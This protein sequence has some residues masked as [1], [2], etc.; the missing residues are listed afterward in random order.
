MRA[1]WTIP[2]T[3]S[4]FR[5]RCWPLRAASR[6]CRHESDRRAGKK[7]ISIRTHR[8]GVPPAFC[9]AGK[10]GCR[11]Q[12][13]EYARVP[14]G[15]FWPSCQQVGTLPKAFTAQQLHDLGLDDREVRSQIAW[16]TCPLIRSS[17]WSLSP[18]V[19]ES[20]RKPTPS[21]TGTGSLAEAGEGAP[22]GEAYGRGKV[23]PIL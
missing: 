4:G 22:N 1:G 7:R 17:S 3:C 19:A 5:P 9:T 14:P 23:R 20:Y 12:I 13:L 11:E 10:P 6:E 16:T 18:P 15:D 2:A 21:R 8:E